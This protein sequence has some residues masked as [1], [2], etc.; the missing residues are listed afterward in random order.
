M[1]LKVA[2]KLLCLLI[3]PSIFLFTIQ[4]KFLSKCLPLYSS[5]KFEL[6]ISE[7]RVK[8]FS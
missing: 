2:K 7:C 3:Y 1:K 8:H 5:F 4:Y 6:I